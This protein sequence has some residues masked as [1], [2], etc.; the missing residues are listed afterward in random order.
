[1]G[2]LMRVTSGRAFL[3]AVDLRIDSKSLG[4]WYGIELSSTDRKQVWAPA[5]FA[6]GVCV[7][8]EAA[9]IQYLCT[10]VYNQQAESGIRWNDPDIGID[11]P[12]ES[13]IVSEKDRQAGTLSEW[14]ESKESYSFQRRSDSMALV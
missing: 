3:V 2:K 6:R 8:S 9:A 5:G 1:M 14:L 7:L 10:G 4:Q 12:I 11:W 13:P